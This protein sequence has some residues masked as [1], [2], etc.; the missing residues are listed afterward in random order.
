MRTVPRARTDGSA[1]TSRRSP[2]SYAASV[3]TATVRQ[4]SRSSAAPGLTAATSRC[5][6]CDAVTVMVIAARTVWFVLM[7]ASNEIVPLV[8][9]SAAVNFTSTGT[10]SVGP[11]VPRKGLDHSQYRSY[12]A[13]TLAKSPYWFAWVPLL[14]TQN[15][16]VVVL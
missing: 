8:P 13:Q 1:C 6:T 9:A 16:C 10:E 7:R 11:I 4:R 12:G 5:V 15:R 2:H 14:T 3:A